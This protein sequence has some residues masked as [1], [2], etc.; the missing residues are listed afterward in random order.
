MD[1]NELII[2]LVIGLVIFIVLL[3]ASYRFVERITPSPYSSQQ[4]QRVSIS[5]GYL[6]GYP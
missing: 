2:L 1:I 3:L 6:Y 4:T 5:K